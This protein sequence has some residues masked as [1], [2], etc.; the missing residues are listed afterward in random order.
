[1]RFSADYDS[2]EEE[3]PVDFILEDTPLCISRTSP[4]ID[5]DGEKHLRDV[6]DEVEDEGEL[7]DQDDCYIDPALH[8]SPRASRDI[9]VCDSGVYA[10]YFHV[11]SS[12]F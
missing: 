12:E 7:N 6:G 2:E 11:S 9:V 1:M 3:Y 5:F 4:S 8:N 10:L